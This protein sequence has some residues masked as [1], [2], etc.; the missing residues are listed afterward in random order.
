[1]GDII[2]T[3]PVIRCLNAQLGA[4]IHFVTRRQNAFLLDKNPHISKILTVEKDPME[5][6]GFFSSENY[7]FVIDLHN[8]IRTRRFTLLLNRPT[9]RFSKLNIKKW[10]LVNFNVNKLPHI[11][12]V[13]RY[14]QASAVLGVSNDHLGLEYYLPDNAQDQVPEYSSGI[15]SDYSVI[16]AG[17]KHFTKQIPATI[18]QQVAARLTGKVI[19]LGGTEDAEKGRQIASI[20]TK[21]ITNY[22]GKISFDASAWIISKA[23]VVITSDTGLMHVAAAFN[24]PIITLWGN[25]VPE[26]GMYPYIPKDQNLYTGIENKLLDCRPCSKIGFQKCPRGHFKCML[27]ADVQKI[28]T[29]ANIIKRD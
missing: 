14:F 8:N 12:I 27:E 25:T 7:D 13:D 24:R 28:T 10:L 29:L 19:I 18:A 17:A 21:R 22:C 26:F 2:L 16:V 20:D 6:F 11:H 23:R 15:D 3:T 9:S 1:M 5:L 4:N